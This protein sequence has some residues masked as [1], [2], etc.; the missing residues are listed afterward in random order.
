M[1]ERWRSVPGY[2][3]FYEV[4]DHGRL[5]SLRRGVL[6]SQS[7]SSNGYYHNQFWVNGKAQTVYAHHL[8][9]AAFI[10]PRPAGLDVCHANGNKLDNRLENLRYDT[11][12]ANIN[13]MVG[14]GTHVFARR[15]HCKNGHE[16]TPENT[17]VRS[18]GGSRRCREC[19]DVW[20]KRARR[21][22]REAAASN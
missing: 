16:F 4:S 7:I 22:K 18:D 13:E 8:V 21:K 19:K 10:G 15:T 6:M 2:E 1:A 3:G 5:K 12:Q 11:R 17:L 9:A 14:H 20:N